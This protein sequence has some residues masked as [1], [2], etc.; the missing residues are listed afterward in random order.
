MKKANKL[1]IFFEFL[2]IFSIFLISLKYGSIENSFSDLWNNSQINQII[3]QL[4]FPRLILAFF[5]GALLSLCGVIYQN[6]L[7]NPL[8]D[9]FLLGSANGAGLANMSIY[10]FLPG[11]Y[12]LSKVVPLLASIIGA[13]LSILIVMKITYWFSKSLKKEIIIL[14]GVILGTFFSSITMLF[15]VFSKKQ[16]HHIIFFLMGNF[17]YI[18][19]KESAILDYSMIFITFSVWIY[20]LMHHKELDLMSLGESG[21]KLSGLNTSVF[22]KKM[23]YLTS[24]LLGISVAYAGI[25]SFAGF[26]VPHITRLIVGPKSLRML[27]HAPLIGGGIILLCDLLSR[28]VYNVELPISIFTALLGAPFFIYILKFGKKGG[29]Y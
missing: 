25:I 4:R 8:A 14:S 22:K 16:L 3:W 29:W 2:I 6:I 28:T 18:W 1:L 19:S 11:I 13:F 17:S 23:F 7:Q 26:I 5:T 27:I 10:L 24:V 21:A 9:P 15:M 20:L 12:S